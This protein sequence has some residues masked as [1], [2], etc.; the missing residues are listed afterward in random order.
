MSEI[1]NYLLEDIDKLSS[2]EIVKLYKYVR[3]NMLA[4]PEMKT[5]TEKSNSIDCGYG[6]ADC[7]YNISTNKNAIVCSLD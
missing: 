2:E 4:S 7:C 5:P 3:W 6:C 1:K